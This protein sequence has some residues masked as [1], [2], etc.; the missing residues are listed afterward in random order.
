[1]K[2]PI[3][4]GI[5]GEIKDAHDRRVMQGKALA[6]KNILGTKRIEGVLRT[7]ADFRENFITL[8]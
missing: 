2:S 3:A 6:V 4:E 5:W 8:G 7:G 1:M